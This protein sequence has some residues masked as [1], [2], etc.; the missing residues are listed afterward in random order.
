MRYSFHPDARHDLHDA[1]DYYKTKSDAVALAFTNQIS[2]AI[3]QIILAPHRW[4]QYEHGTQRFLLSRFP[5]AIV[6][7][8]KDK[9]VQ[10]VAVAHHKRMPGYWAPRIV[11]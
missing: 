6:Y 7:R 1:Q 11:G 8:I 3:E 5:Y 9:E 10:I 2:W 4:K